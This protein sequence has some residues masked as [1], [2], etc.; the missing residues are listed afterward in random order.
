MIPF[1]LETVT[2]ACKTIH[3]NTTTKEQKSEADVFLN[4]LL[5]SQEAWTITRELVVNSNP[6]D[7]DIIFMGANILYQKIKQDYSTLSKEHRQEL[8][9]FL[10]ATV[11]K[12]TETSNNK[13][14]LSM[15][16]RIYALVGLFQLGLSQNPTFMSSVYSQ[17]DPNNLANLSTK[18]IGLLLSIFAEIAGEY[19]SLLLERKRMMFIINNLNENKDNI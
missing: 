19:E 13:L 16:C 12:I 8:D 10:L 11:Q 1:T 9:N 17:I 2:L 4:D 15:V 3:S 14:V 7:F 5:N 6:N 18:Q